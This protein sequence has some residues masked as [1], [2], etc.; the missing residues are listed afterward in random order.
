MR[1]LVTGAASFLGRKLVSA[2]LQQGRMRASDG[3]ERPI[4]RIVAFGVVDPGVQ[5]D[6]RVTSVA[7]D[8][9]DPAQIARLIDCETSSVFHL[10]AIVSGQAEQE[11]DLGMRINVDATRAIMERIRAVAPGAKLLITRSVAVFGGEVPDV[12]PDT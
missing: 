4:E 12:V 1:I 3:A 7:G 11:F 6:A 9:S 8:I 10:A 2:L 5:P